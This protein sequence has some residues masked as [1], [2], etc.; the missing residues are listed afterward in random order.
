MAVKGSLQHTIAVGPNM[1]T[2]MH[3]CMHLYMYVYTVNKN[4][5]HVHGHAGDS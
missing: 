1:H 5:T 4:C 2:C 3:A